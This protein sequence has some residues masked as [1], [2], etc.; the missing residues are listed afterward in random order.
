[1]IF[2]NF[3]DIYYNISFFASNFIN[4]G[5][6]SLLLTLAKCPSFLSFQRINSLLL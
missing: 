5:F 1:M 4:V 6:F 2:L 3:V